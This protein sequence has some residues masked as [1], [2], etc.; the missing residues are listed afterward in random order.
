VRGALCRSTGAKQI[1]SHTKSACAGMHLPGR[2]YNELRG[3]VMRSVFGIKTDNPGW[4]TASLCRNIL[5]FG[6][7]LRHFTIV[8]N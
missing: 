7:F 4:L 6:A 1:V 3:L 8:N 2:D 5:L